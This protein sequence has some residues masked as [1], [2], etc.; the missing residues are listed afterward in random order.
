ML[1]WEDPVKKGMATHSS[2]SCLENP[3]DKGAWRT[4]IHRVTKTLQTW[5]KLLS[6]HT[7]THTHTQQ[8][9]PSCQNVIPPV[10]CFYIVSGHHVILMWMRYFQLWDTPAG[11]F[12]HFLPS[13]AHESCIWAEWNIFRLPYSGEPAPLLCTLSKYLVSTYTIQ[14]NTKHQ[15][16]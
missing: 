11:A 14:D 13:L 12:G 4:K 9:I 1:D 3:M 5:L 6:A 8:Y 16:R 7:H 10:L 2:Y 15:T